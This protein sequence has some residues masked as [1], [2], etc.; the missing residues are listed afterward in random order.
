MNWAEMGIAIVGGLLVGLAIGFPK[1]RLLLIVGAL[2]AIGF[3]AAIVLGFN[4]GV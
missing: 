4:L 1:Y 3:S 2:I